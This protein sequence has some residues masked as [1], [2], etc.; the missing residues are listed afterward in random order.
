MSHKNIISTSLCTNISL[1][2]IFTSTPCSYTNMSSKLNQHTLL[3][4]MVLIN[5]VHFPK[6]S[7]S[8]TECPYPC[9]PSP[10][11]G[12]ESAGALS[13]P[14][15]TGG[16]LSPPPAPEGLIPNTPTPPDRVNSVAL[17][18]PDSVVP[19]YPYYSKRPT[20]RDWVTNSPCFPFLFIYFRSQCIIK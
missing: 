3:A 1:H 4:F 10:P 16:S 12:S 11:T 9:T 18:A 14:Q 19:W 7:S 6:T 20:T 13:P 17:P 5:F 8:E 2:F 15:L